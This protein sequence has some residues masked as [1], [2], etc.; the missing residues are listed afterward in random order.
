MGYEIFIVILVGLLWAVVG[1]IFSR[2]ARRND[3][4]IGFM[5]VSSSIKAVVAW[6]VFPRHRVLMDAISQPEL[7]SSLLLLLAGLSYSVGITLMNKGMKRGH[8]GAT[9]TLGQSALVIPFGMGVLLWSDQIRIWNIAGLIIILAAIF[10]F[11][12]ASGKDTPTQV[13]SNHWLIIVLLAMLFLGVQQ[14]LTTV[15]SRWPDWQDSARLRIPMMW[16]GIMIGFILLNL[17]Q[18]QRLVLTAWREI[19]L[20]CAI[21]LLTSGM[22]F[23]AIDVFAK[24]SRAALVYPAAVGT[25]TTAFSLYSVLILREKTTVYHLSGMIAGIVGVLLVSWK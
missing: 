16:T 14:T 10:L 17:R 20:L 8:H 12:R 21:G 13:S 19:L 4:Y 11:G 1:I 2:V 15:P 5:V 18:R 3:N 7:F 25:C 22:L 9:W 24:S 23:H 6:I